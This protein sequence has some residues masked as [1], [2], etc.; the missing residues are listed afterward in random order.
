MD[1]GIL[2]YERLNAETW[3][4]STSSKMAQKS[5]LADKLCKSSRHSSE[6]SSHMQSSVLLNRTTRMNIETLH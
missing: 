2:L 3:E 6:E 5:S 4:H 1:A